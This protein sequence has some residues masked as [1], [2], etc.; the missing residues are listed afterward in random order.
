M[1]N[2]VP[3]S[4]GLTS[5]PWNYVSAFKHLDRRAFLRAV[6]SPLREEQVQPAS[7]QTRVSSPVA[8]RDESP[9]L[10]KMTRG[11]TLSASI[12]QNANLLVTPLVSTFL[13]FPRPRENRPTLH[14]LCK[15]FPN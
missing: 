7:S 8:P 5:F 9:E 1:R 10:L 2:A 3:R 12:K 13:P 11:F 6:G 14:R 15:S 4:E